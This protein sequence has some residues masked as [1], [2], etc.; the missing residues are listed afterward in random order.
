MKIYGKKIIHI[1]CVWELESFDEKQILE[2]DEKLLIHH[3]NKNGKYIE[4][5]E[6]WIDFEIDYIE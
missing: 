5:G 2:M 3:L 1:D 6:E 4:E